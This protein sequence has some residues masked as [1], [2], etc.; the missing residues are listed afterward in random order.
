M[1]YALAA[2]SLYFF[3]APAYAATPAPASGGTTTN[4][5]VAGWHLECDPGKTT[6]A[7]SVLN[8]V[9][10]QNGALIMGFSVAPTT[11]GKT[12]LT[13]RV[14]L[15]SSV[16]TPVSVSVGTATQ[17]FPFLTCSQQGCFATG[18]LNADLLAAMRAGSGA[19]NVSYALLDSSLTPRGI[20]AS[21]PLSGF[22]QV[23]DKLK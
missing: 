2:L 16:R 18:T 1:R 11:D 6:L 3:A 15:N 17:T 23:Y 21:L 9:Q 10:T 12:G 20:T 8:S 5:A 13:V 14:P 22:G 19:L 4:V 7:C